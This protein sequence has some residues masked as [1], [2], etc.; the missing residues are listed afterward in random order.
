MNINLDYEKKKECFIANEDEFNIIINK[1]KDGLNNIENT[2]IIEDDEEQ[3]NDYEDKQV[4][5]V[6]T[7]KYKYD[8]EKQIKIYKYFL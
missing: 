7:L 4:I 6:E 2:D 1:I 3:I 8:I 5:D